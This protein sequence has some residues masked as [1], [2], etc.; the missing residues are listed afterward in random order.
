[1]GNIFKNFGHLVLNYIYDIY[2]FIKYS[3]VFKKNKE[4]KVLGNIGYFY[5]AIEKGLINDPLRF[6]FGNKKIN[7]LIHYIKDWLKSGFNTSDTQ[8]IAACSVLLKYHRLHLDN[9]IDINDIISDETLDLI[10]K[11]GNSQIGGTLTI[12]AVDYFNEKFSSFES[13]SNSRHSIRHFNGEIIDIEKIEKSISIAR[14]APSV[15]NRQSIEVYLINNKELAQDILKVQSGMN[16]TSE[17]VQQIIIITSEV[18][19]FISP[20]ERNQMFVDGGIFLQNLLYALHF[21]GIAA[22]ALNWS[23]PFFYE[24]NVRKYFKIGH[25]KRII[26]AIAI[27][28][29]TDN[30]KVPFSSRKN[31]NEILHVINT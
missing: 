24:F 12:N 6:R 2:I 13:F 11:Y 19:S 20:V 3:S 21:N 30:F 8:F 25:Q 9:N 5:H 15:C 14:N 23:K 17:K 27:G 1:M 28:Y 22:C 10:S 4:E 18:G 26:S 16:A 7:Q 29:P 31:V